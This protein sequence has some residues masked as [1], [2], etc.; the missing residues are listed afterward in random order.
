MHIPRRDK[1]IKQVYRH[2]GVAICVQV[3]HVGASTKQTETQT[4]GDPAE[5]SYKHAWGDGQGMKSEQGQERRAAK[6][7]EERE[8]E[9]GR[10]VPSQA[11]QDC[12]TAFSRP[13]RDI[14]ENGGR[15]G[16]AGTSEIQDRPTPGSTH[17]QLPETSKRKATSKTHCTCTTL[18]ARQNAS[19]SEHQTR[20]QIHSLRIHTLSQ[21][22]PIL[23]HEQPQDGLHR[24]VDVGSAG[25]LGEVTLEG[26]LQ[27]KGSLDARRDKR[28]T[29]TG[30]VR[31][32]AVRNGAR[33]G[34]AEP[35][36][37]ADAPHPSSVVSTS[38]TPAPHSLSHSTPIPT[39]HLPPVP[40]RQPH[41]RSAAT[42][43]GKIINNA[44]APLPPGGKETE[45]KRRASASRSAHESAPQQRVAHPSDSSPSTTAS[46]RRDR[47]HATH[48]RT[49]L[50]Q[51][52]KPARH[53]KGREGKRV[54]IARC[55]APAPAVGCRALHRSACVARRMLIVLRPR[56]RAHTRTRTRIPL[57]HAGIHTDRRTTALCPLS[58]P[59]EL[60]ARPRKRETHTSETHQ[61]T[62]PLQ[63]RSEPPKEKQQAKTKTRY[64]CMRFCGGG[65]VS[66]GKVEGRWG[67][68]EEEGGRARRGRMEGMGREEC[69][70]RQTEECPAFF[71]VH[72]T[73]SELLTP[74]Q[75]FIV[76]VSA[77]VRDI[78]GLEARLAFGSLIRMRITTSVLG[79]RDATRR[80]TRTG[81]RAGTTTT[82]GMGEWT[83]LILGIRRKAARRSLLQLKSNTKIRQPSARS[84][85]PKNKVAED[86]T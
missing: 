71:L 65:G 85:T 28:S 23:L 10:S 84:Q 74:H 86:N 66:G 82:S 55:A 68:E 20:Q 51:A 73:R 52:Q 57:L 53:T 83:C 29:A 13:A 9:A 34:V 64:S 58:L 39:I 49:S 32:P 25:V 27:D 35:L 59:L 7:E 12:S 18:P 62:I 46:H 38:P 43:E 76:I 48:A 3:Y 8:I 72:W 47:A 69:R 54:Y 44:R 19:T 67:N 11:V 26:D 70:G 56:I 78:S 61:E 42:A 77:T 36:S 75:F 79:W 33:Q 2:P 37:S 6:Q 60:A 63:Q 5:Y 17:S 30:I 31:M 24:L 15:G 40:T 21:P 16:R 81:G 80:A 45:R 22:C 1:I 41:A 14:Q 4:D 50:L